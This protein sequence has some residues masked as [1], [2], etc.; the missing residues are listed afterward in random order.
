VEPVAV[1]KVS[2]TATPQ[3]LEP[4]TQVVAVAVERISSGVLEAAVSLSSSTQCKV[5][6]SRLIL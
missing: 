1:E 5:R 4:L 6:Q 3:I 2:V